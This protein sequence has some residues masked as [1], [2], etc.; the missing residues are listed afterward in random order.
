MRGLAA[1][2]VISLAVIVVAWFV[3]QAVGFHISLSG[4]V[5]LTIGLTLVLNFV[6]AVLHRR[7]VRRW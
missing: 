4:S 6:L 3:G 5:V 2:I 7:S 1:S